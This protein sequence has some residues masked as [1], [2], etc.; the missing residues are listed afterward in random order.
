MDLALFTDGAYIWPVYRNFEAFIAALGVPGCDAE[1]LDAAPI[2]PAH[3]RTDSAVHGVSDALDR[4]LETLHRDL[5][6]ALLRPV[7]MFEREPRPLAEVFWPDLRGTNVDRLF[8]AF[9]FFFVHRSPAELPV[10]MGL[11]VLRSVFFNHEAVEPSLW[12]TSALERVGAERRQLVARQAEFKIPE[13]TRIHNLALAL[14]L[15]S[16]RPAGGPGWLTARIT[17]KSDG[18]AR[19]RVTYGLDPSLHGVALPQAV[20]ARLDADAWAG[21]ARVFGWREVAA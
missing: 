20:L 14:V 19:A 12:L 18:A 5:Y 7:E 15:D 4:R 17:R 13:T 8:A 11:K 10:T 9:M 3:E 6:D 1:G 2:Y 16:R 21:L